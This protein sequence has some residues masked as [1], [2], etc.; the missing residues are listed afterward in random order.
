MWKC[1]N[2]KIAS[3]IFLPLKSDIKKSDV[4]HCKKCG[5]GESKI[6]YA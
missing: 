1:G 5:N 3:S 6:R 2:L 4:R